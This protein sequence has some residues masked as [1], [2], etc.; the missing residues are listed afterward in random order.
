MQ[1]VRLELAVHKLSNRGFDKLAED[2]VARYGYIDGE[3][4][5]QNQQMQQAR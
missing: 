2:F 3:E 4:E 1:A 5:A